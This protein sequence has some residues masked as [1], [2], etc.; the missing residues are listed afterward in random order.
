MVLLIWLLNLKDSSLKH[1]DQDDLELEKALERTFA[2]LPKD[3]EEEVFN[4]M[5]EAQH[6][7]LTYG[8][9][10]EHYGVK[11]MKWG[12]RKSDRTSNVSGNTIRTS[13]RG[14]IKGVEVI[15]R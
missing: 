14:K 3:V 7:N 5:P 6:I 12:V 15:F 10:L 13:K 11:G 1:A 2:K 8:D 9:Y 4:N